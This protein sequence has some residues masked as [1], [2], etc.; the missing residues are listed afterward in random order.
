MLALCVSMC[1]PLLGCNS[2]DGQPADPVSDYTQ[3]LD[4]EFDRIKQEASEFA[5]DSKY[6]L[7]VSKTE[8]LVSPLVGTC[9]VR[10]LY[11][12][13]AD[14]N[15]TIVVFTLSLDM[16]HGYQEGKWVLTTGEATITDNK[17]IKDGSKYQTAGQ[18]AQ[19]M[20]GQKHNFE[21]LDEL[22]KIF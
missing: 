12:M 10:V 9:V 17:V 3:F 16:K 8:S 20:T 14:N 21:T 2:S 18:V 11:P 1:F 5:I 19:N 15:D 4:G 6:K 13:I 22:G 7:D